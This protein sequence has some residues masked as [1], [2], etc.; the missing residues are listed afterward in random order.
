MDSEDEDTWMRGKKALRHTLPRNAPPLTAPKP[1][2]Y[3]ALPLFGQD[4]NH[5]G[6]HK[7]DHV[8]HFVADR[9]ADLEDRS[10]GR[11]TS[12]PIKQ[13][14]TLGQG[15]K[16]KHL[17]C[18]PSAVIEIKHHMV[19]AGERA[20]CYHQA[21]N[22][23]STALSLLSGLSHFS[24]PIEDFSEMQPVVAFTFIGYESK[25]WVAYI[26]TRRWDDGNI[27]CEYVSLS[28]L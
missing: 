18:F 2:L 12:N 28:S 26:S 14:G 3:M 5:R 11:F 1:D 8:Q 24:I 23:A 7:G 27:R 4:L 19:S 10:N 16:E 22:G 20:K 9:L 6:F 17:L 21:A 25:V 15:I 13:L